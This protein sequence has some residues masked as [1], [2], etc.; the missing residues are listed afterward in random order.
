MMVFSVITEVRIRSLLFY[1]GTVSTWNSQ[2]PLV[3]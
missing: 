1:S 3:R 2:F